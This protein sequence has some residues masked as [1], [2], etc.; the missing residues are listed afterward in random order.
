[1]ELRRHR[2]QRKRLRLIRE[3]LEPIVAEVEHHY[4][5]YL[6]TPD[7]VELRNIALVARLIVRC[8]LARKESRGLHYISDYPESNDEKWRKDT[9]IAGA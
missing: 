1:M 2:P 7:L 8:A 4:R 6:L 3:Q 9:I 5:D